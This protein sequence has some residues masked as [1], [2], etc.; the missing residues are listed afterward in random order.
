MV[1]ALWRDDGDRDRQL[2]IDGEEI[3][4]VHVKVTEL[5]GH[6]GDVV[7][8]QPWTLHCMSINSLDMPRLAVTHTVHRLGPG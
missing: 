2:M 7:V 8:M 4:G 5:T 3:D 1:P 6:A